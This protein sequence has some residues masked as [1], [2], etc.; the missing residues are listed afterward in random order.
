[1]KYDQL[2]APTN[3]A[4]FGVLREIETETMQKKC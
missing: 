3:R 4:V 1:M 2:P